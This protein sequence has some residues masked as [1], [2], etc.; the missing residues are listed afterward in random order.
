MLDK[1][2]QVNREELKRV[3]PN[4]KDSQYANLLFSQKQFAG[5]VRASK[6]LLVLTRG[7]A[8]FL[9]APTSQAA[10]EMSVLRR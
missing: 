6:M 5:S 2:R 1:L 9:E 7:P 3:D 4:F 10:K 8:S